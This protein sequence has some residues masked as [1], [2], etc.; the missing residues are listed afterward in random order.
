MLNYN[1]IFEYLDDMARKILHPKVDG[2]I[3]WLDLQLLVAEMVGH[4]IYFMMLLDIEVIQCFSFATLLML[5]NQ[6][7]TATH[8]SSGFAPATPIV[9]ERDF[10][11]G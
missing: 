5:C 2:A 7:P 8:L 9:L 1:A 10:H 3:I 4:L 11:L 6:V